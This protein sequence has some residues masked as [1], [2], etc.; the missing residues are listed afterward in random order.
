MGVVFPPWGKQMNQMNC[1]FEKSNISWQ[2]DWPVCC[3]NNAVNG[4]HQL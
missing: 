4:A 1:W 2:A 3:W